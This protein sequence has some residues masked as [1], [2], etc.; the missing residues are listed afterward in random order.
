MLIDTHA[1]L[2]APEFAEDLPAVLARAEAAGVGRM[3]CVGYDL[4]TSRRAVDLAERDE[5]IF[6]T[7]GVHPNDV[8]SAPPDWRDA[9]EGLA[10][11][12]RV[13]AI[14][15]S[16]LDFYREFTPISAQEDA[17]RW[18]LDLA[19]RLGLPIVLHNRQSDAALTTIL[20]DWAAR[21]RG[22]GTPGVLHSFC[23][24][25]SMMAACAE[26]GFAVSFSGMVTF[27]NKSLAYLADLVRQAP[28]SALMVETDAPYL[29]PVPFRGK[30][31]EPA[32]VR[33]TAERVA[34]IRDALIAEIE[35]LTTANAHRVFAHLGAA[36]LA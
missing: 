25:V 30:R 10:G 11:H 23:G 27:A 8:A 32:Y 7:I 33:A 18:H 9:I 16:G 24:D 29:A 35:Q 12:P 19:D 21:R 31:N 17:L 22:S 26:A 36:L 5:R 20:L 3:I 2:N 4:A 1:H 13:V 34:A 14:G 28:D 6:A 15:E